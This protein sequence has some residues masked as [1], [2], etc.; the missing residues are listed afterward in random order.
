MK[1]ILIL[2]KTQYVTDS[3]LKD[4]DFQKCPNYLE[5]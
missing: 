2:Y 1:V 4:F 5:C 3:Q